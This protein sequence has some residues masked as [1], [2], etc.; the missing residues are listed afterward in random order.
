M[1][2]LAIALIVV[3]IVCPIVIGA[4]LWLDRNEERRQ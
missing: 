4:V 2:D 1:R 3:A